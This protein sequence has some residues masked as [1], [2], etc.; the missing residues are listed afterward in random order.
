MNSQ[1]EK[2]STRLLTAETVNVM[3]NKLILKAAE[4]SQLAYQDLDDNDSEDTELWIVF[5]G[6]NELRDVLM[7]LWAFRTSG[8]CI[9][10][11]IHK[12]F[13]EAF[14][15]VALHIETIV[16]PEMTHERNVYCVGHSA[17]GALA[18]ICASAYA[19][20][21][22]NAIVFGCPR[23]G[24]RKF[25]KGITGQHIRVVN[26]G[27]LVTQMPTA[28]RFFHGGVEIWFNQDGEVTKPGWR[29][30]FGELAKSIVSSWSKL[31][32]FTLTNH[33]VDRYVANCELLVR[34]SD[35]QVDL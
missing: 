23:T 4:F 16:T 24:T 33:S 13:H 22:A 6:T 15:K 10:G 21:F 9:P 25:T 2:E 26:S 30:R 32:S 31:E 8:I 27:D 35:K 29:D 5:T 7:D 19:G 34:K 18:T 11:K 17:G 14:L 12:G 28:L 3:D 20:V 1:S